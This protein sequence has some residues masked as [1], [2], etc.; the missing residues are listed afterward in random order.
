M[1]L[2][3]HQATSNLTTYDTMRT[4]VLQLSPSKLS[5][6][7]D[8]SAYTGREGYLAD[9]RSDVLNHAFLPTLPPHSRK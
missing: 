1:N 4:Q 8:P 5:L 7:A 6:L 2:P 3:F 9:R